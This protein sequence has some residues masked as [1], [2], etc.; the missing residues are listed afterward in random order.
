MGLLGG[1]GVCQGYGGSHCLPH[2][3]PGHMLSHTVYSCRLCQ[4]MH[5]TSF[6]PMQCLLRRR[7]PGAQLSP[8]YCLCCTGGSA[9]GPLGGVP[10]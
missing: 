7:Q 3:L 10:C 2:C 6:Q 1:G 9:A 8:R 4:L 5:P